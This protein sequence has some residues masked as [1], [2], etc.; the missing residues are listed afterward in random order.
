MIR[1]GLILALSLLCNISIAQ[2][3]EDRLSRAERAVER[4]QRAVD[5]VNVLIKEARERYAAEPESRELI[6]KQLTA[7]EFEALSIKRRYDQELGA[8]A[9]LEQQIL[10]TSVAKNTE[11]VVVESQVEVQEELENVPQR[12]NLVYNRVFERSMSA[13][14]LRALKQAQQQEGDV[15]RKIREYLRVYDKMVAV[16]LEYERVDSEQAA[17]SLLQSLDSLRTKAGAVEDAANNLWH[18]LFDNKLY[19]YNLMMEKGGKLDVVAAAETVLSNAQSLSEQNTSVYESDVLMEYFY[20]KSAMLDY[21]SRVAETLN[22]NKAKDSLISVK[23][24]LEQNNFCLPKVNI[25][26]RSFIEYEPLKVIKPTIY[27]SKNPIPNTRIYE[28]GTLYR[29]RIGIFTNRPNLSA[30]KGITP[31]SYTDK[32]HSG[33]YAYFVGCFPTEEE[34]MRGVEYLKK[35]GFRSP[36]V[37]MWVDGEYISNI[38]EWKSK[39]VGFKIEITG[40]A[41]LP[42]EIKAHISLRNEKA[43]F[44][45]IGSAFVVGTFTSKADAEKVASEIVAMSGNLKVE[46]KSIK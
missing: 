9:Q 17:D 26:R 28:F 40:V 27:T 32:Y 38:E 3:K 14:D 16:Q 21:E 24:G 13:S 43:M 34:A 8:L 22:L 2:T 35:L 6:V 44:S 37:V 41:S 33:K 10:L 1:L 19:A 45:R 20:R 46:V 5:S 12:A 31:L 36:V 4:A 30:L 29:I 39:N 23:R 11:Q 25:V 15:V 7:L 42:D 18:A